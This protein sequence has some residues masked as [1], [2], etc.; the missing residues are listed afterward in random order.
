MSTPSPRA[1]TKQALRESEARARLLSELAADFAYILRVAP[2]GTLTVEWVSDSFIHP[3]RLR[4][5][6]P[7]RYRRAAR[8]HSPR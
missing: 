6:A 3:D 7:D 5:R 4:S 8:P 2:D 1:M